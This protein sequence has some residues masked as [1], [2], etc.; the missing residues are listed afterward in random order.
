MSIL[1]VPC[2]TSLGLSAT[3]PPPEPQEEDTLYLLLI[4]KSKIL[5]EEAGLEA[6]AFA[7]RQFGW[8]RSSSNYLKGKEFLVTRALTTKVKFVD[9]VCPA[10]CTVTVGV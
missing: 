8:L 10:D 1:N 3:N 2:T 9:A 5:R 7:N 6:S 4:V